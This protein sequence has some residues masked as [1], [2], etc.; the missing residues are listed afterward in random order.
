MF[1]LK[2]FPVY[3]KLPEKDLTKNLQ[4]CLRAPLV[5]HSVAMCDASNICNRIASTHFVNISPT[6]KMY[7]L[8]EVV[9]G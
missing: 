8:P 4:L 9:I 1:L 3:Y 5:V 6:T 2:E 7:E